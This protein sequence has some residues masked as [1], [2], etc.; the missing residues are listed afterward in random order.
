MAADR[1][2]VAYLV[3]RY[4]AVSHTFIRDE[5]RALRG[6]G[7]EILTFS[8]WRSP[9]E[10][11]LSQA[12]REERDRTT[13]LIPA[14]PLTY[15]RAAVRLSLRR[16]GAAAA[17]VRKARHLRGP[18]LRAIGLAATW[19]LEA[20]VVWDRCE[21]AGIRHVHAHLNGTAPAVAAIVA[22][23]GTAADPGGRRWTW[24]MTVHGP[25]EFYDVQKE[26]L[27]RKVRDA[28]LVACIT[29]FTRSQLMGMVEP[30]HWPKLQI[31][32]CGVV[33]DKLTASNGDRPR[34]ATGRTRILSVGRLTP[35]KGHAV[36]LQACRTMLREDVDFELV[37]VGDG[38]EAERLR[39]EASRL[40]LDDRVTWTGAVGHDE[41]ASIYA[42]ADVFCL[43]SFA[44]GLPVVLME[45]MAL[46]LPVV[47]SRIM[48]IPELVVHGETGLLVT[49]G[50]AGELA[51]ALTAVVRDDALRQSFAEAGVR[52]VRERHRV[53]VSARR[54]ADHF[55]ALGAE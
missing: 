14:S 16:P 25:T 9:D 12:D 55:S 51:A 48:G 8:V 20:A 46:R 36:L 26:R 30:D 38:P 33:I 18:G 7:A 19:V 15:L 22:A 10:E 4:P 3:G 13:H 54:L 27:D 29:E 31:V 50:D 24:S 17:A 39:A 45:A 23:A 5:I 44:E 40:E 53:E 34:G 2:R 32:R 49:P 11:V 47:A 43:A 52:A 42:S 21:R 6:L 41:I 1:P 28:D 37:V 35:V